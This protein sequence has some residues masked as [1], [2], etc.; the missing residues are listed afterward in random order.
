MFRTND[1]Y[2]KVWGEH[3][4]ARTVAAVGGKFVTVRNLKL[5][6]GFDTGLFL[7]ELSGALEE[8]IYDPVG[9]LRGYVTRRGEHPAVIPD[10]FVDRLFGATVQSGWVFSDLKT[11]NVIR[12]GDMYSLIDFDTHLSSLAAFDPEF[13]RK[14]GSLRDH[15][16]TRYKDRLLDHIGKQKR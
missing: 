14:S 4:V 10:D 5:L 9:I 3:F 11:G 12:I 7:P 1:R 2:Y 16:I 13:E 15:V 8:F 6:H